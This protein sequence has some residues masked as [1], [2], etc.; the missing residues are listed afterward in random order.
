MGKISDN[1]AD[2]LYVATKNWLHSIDPTNKK[3]LDYREGINEHLGYLQIMGMPQPRKLAHQYVSL[4]TISTPKKY[5]PSC[6]LFDPKEQAKELAAAKERYL[7]VRQHYRN[8]KEQIQLLGNIEDQIQLLADDYPE[9]ASEEEGV[10]LLAE[11]IQAAGAISEMDKENSCAK[12]NDIFSNKSRYAGE[13]AINIIDKSNKLI[14]LG[15]PGSGKT[16][17]LKFVA[18]VYSTNILIKE[19]I[20]PLLPIFIPLRYYNKETDLESFIYKSADIFSSNIPSK[21]WLNA[22]IKKGK[23]IFLFDGLDEVEIPSTKNCIEELKN[24]K[25]KHRKNKFVITC[26][27]ACY[28]GQFE[29]FNLCEIDDFDLEDKDNFLNQWYGD[30][31]DTLNKIKKDLSDSKSATDLTKSPLL[32]TLLCIQYDYSYSIPRSRTELYEHCIDALLFR[33]DAFKNID[34]GSKLSNISI[35]RE[36]NMMSSIAKDTFDRELLFFQR[37]RLVQWINHEI[38]RLGLSNIDS[39][40]FIDEIE[41]NHGLLVERA[42]G[43]Y[44]FSHLS[45]HEYFTAKAY[46]DQNKIDKLI[47]TQIYNPRY[48]EVIIMVAEK[49]SLADSF[50]IKILN[51]VLE[52]RNTSYYKWELLTKLSKAEISM[53]PKIRQA[54][55][56][57]AIDFLLDSDT[58]SA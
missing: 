50:I 58:Q 40:D 53:A 34:R 28:C 49:L 16:T 52:D 11:M 18:L 21:I 22:L 54:M 43:I 25:T 44:S 38:G 55:N 33:W 3:L 17:F 23:C 2:D 10:E 42:K 14:I 20:K 6:D 57:V 46:L 31:N 48:L 29:G 13:N 39:E 9:N 45:F 5:I 35:D 15:Q 26:R 19:P 8:I 12:E 1:I 4:R 24:F 7:S 41:A 30:N 47:E 32:L 27:S 36:K 56:D 51:K 37:K